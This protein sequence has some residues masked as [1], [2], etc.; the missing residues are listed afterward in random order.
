MNVCMYVCMKLIQIHISE[1]IWAKLCTRLPLGLEETVGYAWT[2][3]SWPLWPFGHFFF[4]AHCR[5][6]GTRWL[7]A[8]PFS[9]IP[10]YPWLQLVFA[11]RHRHYVVADGGVIR[12]SLMSVIL[13]GVPLTS[14]KWRSRRQSHLP[15]RRIP[16]S[17][18][19][20]RH[21]TDI[22]FI[23]ATGPSATA[24]YPSSGSCFC[25][26]QEITSLQTT[27]ARSYSKCVALS[28]LRTIRWDVNG[29][30]VSTIRNP[31]RRKEVTKELQLYK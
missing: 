12:G 8:R 18:G 19:C 23:R 14:R 25:D 21:V 30:H 13:A 27:V 28:V 1:P 10:L 29:I 4:G 7:P 9:A 3:D 17:G 2:R 20:S 22:T 11:S 26:L 6:V 24:L 31:I 5:I 16:F 15:Q